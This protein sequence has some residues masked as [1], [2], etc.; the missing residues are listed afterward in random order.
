MPFFSLR[1]KEGK[2]LLNFASVINFGFLN[3]GMVSYKNKSNQKVVRSI[4]DFE[5]S[6]QLFKLNEIDL[7]HFMGMWS[8]KTRNNKPIVF[9]NS[10]DTEMYYIPNGSP[11]K[12]ML[13]IRK[14][15]VAIKP[16]V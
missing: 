8:K 5:S 9:D 15:E 3:E 2:S 10:I 6:I 13:E 1:K 16:V 11:L 4:S 14:H 7:N 12:I